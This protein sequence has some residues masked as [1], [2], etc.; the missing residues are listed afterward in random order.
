MFEEPA[1]GL[2]RSVGGSSNGRAIFRHDTLDRSNDSFRLIRVLPER[3]KEGLIQLTLWQDLISCAT[4]QCLSYC[5]G[6][7]TRQHAVVINGEGFSVGENLFGF[8]Q[9]VHNNN[10]QIDRESVFWIDALCINQSSVQERGHQVQRMGHIYSEAQRVLIWLGRGHI[11]APALC[12]WI[13]HQSRDECPAALLSH[14]DQVRRDPYWYRAWIVQE[15]LL[16][17]SVVVILPGV[18]IDYC[19]LGRAIAK[20]TDLS[21]IEQE[22]AAQ[23][24]TFWDDH[25][26]KP[27]D[28]AQA[29]STVHWLRHERDHNRFWELIHLQKTSKCA[30]K[31]DRV[32]SLLGLV[33]GDLQ[34]T[35]DYD[36]DAV[37]LFWRA[38]EHFNAWE[39]PELVDILRIALLN[40]TT[41]HDDT[42]RVVGESMDPWEL[43]ESLRTRPDLRIRIP[44]RRATPTA[45]LFNRH[46][47]T[48]RCESRD[49]RRAPPMECTQNDILL[50][51]NAKS[52]GPTEHGCI[53]ALATRLDELP[54]ESFCLKLEAHH[55]KQTARADLPSDALQVLNMATNI[56]NSIEDWATFGEMLDKQDLDR[57]DR[58]KLLI[59]AK[60]AI[61][62]WYGVHPS[63]LEQ[64]YRK[65]HR[66]LPSVQHILP[67]GTKISKSSIHMFQRSNL[68]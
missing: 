37:D 43:V 64:V 66:D 17:K 56:W 54:A 57:T 14:W 3:S 46:M 68:V 58:V 50:C 35:V 39:A 53:H 40:N 41:S 32:Y 45:P 65:Q 29:H 15:V 49:C 51:T 24:W 61:W 26:R 52:S 2:H 55:G 25:W 16:S 6:N 7:P 62:I 59:P 9:E 13:L 10:A 8:L 42:D 19:L 44:V 20:Y 38:G 28:R 4:Y 5:W 23:L 31:R 67:L 47:G 11:Q 30:D 34:F 27:R 33:S 63:E 36:E 60:Y 18:G 12:N 22:S 21:R 48:V 1:P